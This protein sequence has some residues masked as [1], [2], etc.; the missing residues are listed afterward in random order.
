MATIT[1]AV[2]AIEPAIRC[3]ESLTAG[4]RDRQRDLLAFES[5][6]ELVCLGH[7]DALTLIDQAE[8]IRRAIGT[9]LEAQARPIVASLLSVDEAIMRSAEQA[10]H[11]PERVRTLLHTATVA[12]ERA[13]RVCL[14]L[15]DMRHALAPIARAAASDPG[16]GFHARGDLAEASR[17]LDGARRSGF[18]LTEELPTMQ[19]RLDR[20][21]VP[22]GSGQTAPAPASATRASTPL[23]FPPSVNGRPSSPPAIG[24]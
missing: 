8:D 6:I 4:L 17:W 3:A 20:L 22:S 10:P 14:D 16:L 18:L 19:M 5:T 1:E 13:R 21:M 15:T 11:A 7:G 9:H 2:D 23:G 24:R 12:G